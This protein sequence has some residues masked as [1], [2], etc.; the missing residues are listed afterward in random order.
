MAKETFEDY[1]GEQAADMV[2]MLGNHAEEKGGP[3]AWL[4]GNP[5]E[6]CRR[7]ERQ[8]RLLRE[9]IY[10]RNLAQILTRTAHACNY[11]MMAS[12]AA[13]SQNERLAADAR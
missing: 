8:L 5:L 7:A 1:V 11:A 2:T 10:G 9:A 3:G 4:D 13:R 6:W 12:Q